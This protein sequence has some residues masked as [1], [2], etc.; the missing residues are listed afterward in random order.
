MHT[1]RG[2][3]LRAPCTDGIL[4]IQSAVAYGH[5]GNSAAVFP[6]QR[7]GFEVWPV[8]TVLFSNHTGYGAW[9]GRG[10]A[11]DWLQ[12]I[13]AGIAERGASATSRRCCRAISASPDLGEAV[14]RTVAKVA[15][16]AP[17]HA[18]CLRPGHGRRGPRLFRQAGHPRAS[19]ATVRSGRPTWLPRT[20]SSSPGS[21]IAPI[22]GLDDA[23]AA[24]APCAPPGPGIVV[25]T[26]VALPDDPRLGVLAPERARPAGLHDPAAAG[27]PSTAPAMP[28]PPCSSARGCAPGQSRKPWR[29]P[30]GDVRAGRATYAAGSREL[31]LVAAQDSYLAPP[32]L[33]EA[34]RL[35]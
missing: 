13:I 23:L 17:G 1:A 32:R 7:L 5:V 30:F 22:A 34:Q 2:R 3:A 11:L 20:S 24:A 25:C 9:R 26:S 28:S 16:A 35:R 12:E 21:P 33:F 27:R 31:V 29:T 6:L 14:L 8:N 19:S 10:V 15:R 4:S 18:L